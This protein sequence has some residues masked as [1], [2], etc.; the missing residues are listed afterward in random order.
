MFDRYEQLL[1]EKEE[2]QSELE[3]CKGLLHKSGFAK[4]LRILK[5]VI[6]SLEVSHVFLLKC[7]FWYYNSKRFSKILIK[8]FEFER[9]FISIE[10]FQYSYSK[11]LT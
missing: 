5:K 11:S 6:Q 4:E 1:R 3:M 7:K 10:N 8:E 9:K 2:M